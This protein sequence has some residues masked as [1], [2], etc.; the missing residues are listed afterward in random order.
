MV[1]ID[2]APIAGNVYTCAVGLVLLLQSYCF[3][4]VVV[5]KFGNEKRATLSSEFA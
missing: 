2:D 1:V 5:V 4:A 3:K